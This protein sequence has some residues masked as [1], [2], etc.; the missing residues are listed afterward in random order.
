VLDLS[1][2]RNRAMRG[3]AERNPALAPFDYDM[4]KIEADLKTY[5][6]NHRQELPGANKIGEEKRDAINAILGIATTKNRERNALSGSFG[7]GSAIKQFRLDRVDAAVGTGRTGFHFD[8]DRA[9][10]NF[11]PDKPAPM[12][13]LSKDLPGQAMP[14]A[15]RD[16]ISGALPRRSAT[17]S[18]KAEVSND[19]TITYKGKEPAQW[20]PQEFEA[21]G[22]E[23]GVR[24]LGPISKISNIVDEL[25]RPVAQIPGGLEGKFTYYDLLHLKAN[26]VDVRTLPVDLHGQLTA[27]LARTMTPDQGNKVQKFNGILFGMLSPNSPLLPN[28]FGQARMRFGSM[29]EIKKFAD[30]LP[31]NPTKDQR[32]AVNERLKKE[33]GFTS[34]KSGGLGIGIS[35]D[36]SNIVIAAKMFHKN[37]DFFIKKPKESW[38]NFVDKLTTQVSGLGTK[39]ASFGGVWQDPL[40]AGISAMDRHMARA[41]SDELL[42]N[43][44]IRG[45][46]EGIVVKRFNDLVTES[47]DTARKADSKI[48]RAKTEKAKAA[49]EQ[50]KATAMQN[51]PDPT[52]LKADTLDDVLGQA[53]IFGADRVKDFV[54]EAVFAA[55]GSRKAKYQM[56]D[57][58]VNPNLPASIQGVEW[59]QTPKDFQVMS[60][61]YRLALE[62]NAERAKSIGIEIFPAQWTLWDRIRG[63]V[64]PH[65]A[66]FPGL[67]K[68]PALN[69]RQLASAFAANKKAGY[70]STPAPGQPWKRKSGI[71]PAELAYFGIPIAAA[72]MAQEEEE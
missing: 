4:G 46:F 45:R 53:E 3:I 28:E 12:P 27:K 52:A 50:E 21:F 32:K 65:E 15:V 44:D 29:D 49:A 7:P 59:V 18:G 33:L 1:Q 38:A 72:A 26:P 14:D 56:K 51:L 70:A 13:D 61:A 47:K 69:D 2:F 22:K 40:K 25:G 11:M 8:Y 66:M 10:R 19:G 42:N 6:E 68:I 54:N 24:N 62:I 20:S 41:F 37:P 23:F 35:V 48:R 31:D 36:L 57:G 30:L 5:M 16:K 63:R 58:S 43:P 55:M 17:V 39:T 67:E 64:E 71:N 9:N 34:A 60:E